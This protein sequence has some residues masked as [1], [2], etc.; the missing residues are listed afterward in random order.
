MPEEAVAHRWYIS[1][2]LSD[3]SPNSFCMLNLGKI[4]LG[5]FGR[6]GDPSASFLVPLG[7]LLFNE[8]GFSQNGASSIWNIVLMIPFVLSGCKAPGFLMFLSSL[9]AEVSMPIYC[10]VKQINS[11]YQ[12]CFSISLNSVTHFLLKLHPLNIFFFTFFCTLI[13]DMNERNE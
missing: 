1:C 8:L 5:N 7:S 11:Y 4:S 10:H 9:T 2:C 13:I 3:H 12:V 6:S